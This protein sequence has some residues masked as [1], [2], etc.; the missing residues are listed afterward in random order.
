MMNF[1]YPYRKCNPCFKEIDT[2][3]PFRLSMLITLPV[4][5][6]ERLGHFTNQIEHSLYLC[7]PFFLY[8]TRFF[9]SFVLLL[10]SDEKASSSFI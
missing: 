4:L 1:C 9:F 5:L 10:K 7:I 3:F 8:E 6:V 2:I